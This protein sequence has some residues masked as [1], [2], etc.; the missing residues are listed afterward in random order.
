[1]CP[2]TTVLQPRLGLT[3]PVGKM[4]LTILAAA[5]EMKSDLL[6]E[7]TKAGLA[8]AKKEGKTLGLPSKNREV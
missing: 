2:Q 3:S 5:T 6:L 1:M 8:S 4:C 7:C